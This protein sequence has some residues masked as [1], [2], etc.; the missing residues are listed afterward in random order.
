MIDRLRIPR[1][2]LLPAAIAVAILTVAACANDGKEQEPQ[3]RAVTTLPVFADIV[4]EIGG[5]R[6][7]TSALLPFGADPH[8]YEP[9]PRQVALITEADVIFAN[10]LQLEGTLITNIIEPNLPTG[11]PLVELADEAAAA[12]VTLLALKG[13]GEGEED[14]PHLWLSVDNTREY[15]RIV[16][17]ALA[18]VDPQGIREYERNYQR[19]SERLAELAQYTQD[20]ASAVPAER[21]KLVTTHDAFGYL[22]SDLGFEVLAFVVD[23]PGQEPSAQ[24][25]AD[26]RRMVREADVAAVFEEPQLGAEATVL[27]QAAADLG[28]EVCTLYSDALDESVPT[29]IDLMRF[30][31]DEVARCLG[32]GT[33]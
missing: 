27:Q 3:V 7:E 8:T 21:R 14:D 29:Y 18:E 30:N 16:R 28:V 23:N 31:A 9:V 22:A 20:R 10:G 5:D 12:G 32:G 13:S 25:V 11:V 15:A 26:L 6:V 19:Y 2:C 33:S 1:R 24:D 4:R 17:D